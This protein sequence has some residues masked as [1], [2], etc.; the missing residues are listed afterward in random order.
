MLG[1]S[2]RRT[3]ES[4]VRG[5]NLT[6]PTAAMRAKEVIQNFCDVACLFSAQA[7]STQSRVSRVG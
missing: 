1:R 7:R 3:R 5:V 4:A 6:T 2:P